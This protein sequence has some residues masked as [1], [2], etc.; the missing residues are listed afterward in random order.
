M[1]RALTMFGLLAVTLGAAAQAAKSHVAYITIRHQTVGCHAWSL[2]NGPFRA[3]LSVTLHAG[4]KIEFTDDDGMS[5]RLVE[6][7]GPPLVLPPAMIQSTFHHPGAGTVEV[8][9]AKRGTYRLGT[10]DDETHSKPLQTSGP[11]NVLRLTVVV[12]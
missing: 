7:A 2:D 9:F 4:D 8:A 5:H 6:L 3:R 12:R 1:K 11:D 10:V